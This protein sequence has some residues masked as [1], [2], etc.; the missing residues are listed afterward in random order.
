MLLGVKF[1][2]AGIRKKDRD[3]NRRI[4]LSKEWA[5]KFIKKKI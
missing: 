2:S 3:I 5:L 4:A 1:V